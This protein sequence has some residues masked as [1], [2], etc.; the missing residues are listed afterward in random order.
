M[1]L[2]NNEAGRKVSQSKELH[3]KSYYQMI[4]QIIRVSFQYNIACFFRVEIEIEIYRILR[5]W[6]LHILMKCIESFVIHH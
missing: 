4:I 1:N 2:H 3:E 5:N 6:Q